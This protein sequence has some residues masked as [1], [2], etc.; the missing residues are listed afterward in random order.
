[1]GSDKHL[2]KKKIKQMGFLKNKEG[3]KKQSLSKK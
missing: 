3:T 1:M 2:N